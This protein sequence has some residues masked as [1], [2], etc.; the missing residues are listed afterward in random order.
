MAIQKVMQAGVH[1]TADAD[2]LIARLTQLGQE[3]VPTMA[4]ETVAPEVHK[5]LQ[6]F[7]V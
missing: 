4:W 2:A 7:N 5:A 1:T 3:M 6:R